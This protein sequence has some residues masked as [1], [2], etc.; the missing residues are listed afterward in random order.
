MK[1]MT[2]LIPII[3]LFVII[4]GS[5]FLFLFTREEKRRLLLYFRWRQLCHRLEKI[6]LNLRRFYIVI[7]PIHRIA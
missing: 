2:K 7:N 3:C 4:G 5:L 1:A 6:V